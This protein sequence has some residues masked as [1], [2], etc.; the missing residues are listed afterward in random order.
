MGKLNSVIYNYKE[1]F[2]IATYISLLLILS[3]WVI[4]I[5][6]VSWKIGYLKS[7]VAGTTLLPF[8]AIIAGIYIGLSLA[9]VIKDDFKRIQGIII[10]IFSIIVLLNFINT[11]SKD[12]VIFLIFLVGSSYLA[13]NH[14]EKPSCGYRPDNK[15][16]KFLTYVALIYITIS[17]LNYYVGWLST[18]QEMPARYQY[19]LV[20][21]VLLGVVF[22]KFMN[23]EIEDA[24]VLVLGPPRVGKT[25]FIA[26]LCDTVDGEANASLKKIIEDDLK[27]I[28]KKEG[29]IGAWVKPTRVLTEYYFIFS[30]G[31]LF[32]KCTKVGTIDYPG[33]YLIDEL[34]EL[35]LWLKDKKIRLNPKNFEELVSSIDF[36]KEWPKNVLHKDDMIKILRKISESSK[37]IFLISAISIKRQDPDMM[38][39]LDEYISVYKLIVEVSEKPFIL[40][41]NK[42]DKEYNTIIDS[43]NNIDELAE[44][45]TK[46]LMNTDASQLISDKRIIR[47][48]FFSNNLGSKIFVCWVKEKDGKPVVVNDKIVGVGYR[49]IAN[50]L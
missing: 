50:V 13:Y 36:S 26:T 33:R 34:R 32:R 41:I 17:L 45:I 39:K 25:V 19:D 20:Y 6:R 38:I 12:L 29:H 1:V 2:T 28:A 24:S 31:I 42:V 15:I 40:V 14:L 30:R 9:I 44:I 35:F 49:V 16:L 37:I 18:L 21:A 3:L 11:I 8:I 22:Y 27:E 7:I 43:V 4:N 47:R 46:D 5:F 23:Y 48:K 10:L